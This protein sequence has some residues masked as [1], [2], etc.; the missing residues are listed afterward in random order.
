MNSGPRT[1]GSDLDHEWPLRIGASEPRP[2][3]CT[4]QDPGPGLA[5]LRIP[6]P[7]R[8]PGASSGSQRRPGIPA[9]ARGPGAGPGSQR[10]LGIPAPQA[11]LGCAAT[12]LL[13]C[14]ALRGA[15][16]LRM[17]DGRRLS[18]AGDVHRTQG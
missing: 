17:G 13:R 3:R 4:A 9:P 16:L 7:A 2:G 6:A 14:A 10:G 15:A 1:P 8:D 5:R 12:L 11:A 18:L